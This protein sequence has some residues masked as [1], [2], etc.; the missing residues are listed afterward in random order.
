MTAPVSLNLDTLINITEYV[1]PL[2]A[3]R[4]TFNQLLVIG[5]AGGA[6]FDVGERV[7]EYTAAADMLDDGFLITD[8]EYLAALLYFSQSPAPTTL[9]VGYKATASPVESYVEA[10]TACRAAN[11]EWY[12]GVCLD[13]LTADHEACAAWAEA[14]VPTSIYAFTTDEAAVITSATTDIFST[15]KGLSY[16]R[17]IGQYSTDDPYAVVAIMGY[18]MGANTG[19]ANSAYTLMFKGEVGIAVEQL[20]QTQVGYIDDKHGNVYLSYGNYYN[21]FQKGIMANGVDFSEILH[22]DMLRNDI[23]LSIM[24][25]LYGTPKIP[26]TDVGQT[27]LLHACNICCQ[28]AVNRGF[29]GAGTWTGVTV[30]NVKNGDM[31]PLGYVCQSAPY[32]TQSQADREA[33]KSMPI[34][35]CIKLSGIV[36]SVVIGIYLNR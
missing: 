27:M 24:D 34:Y 4:A 35:V 20:T 29:L 2:A 30:L 5:T 31:L 32:A 3:P 13:A 19:L 16:S 36:K 22:M 23:Q 6:I 33:N 21:I 10:I 18:A 11:F 8:P 17:T 12:V 9:W 7:R 25:L 15:L 28:A 14:A 26:Q 1:S